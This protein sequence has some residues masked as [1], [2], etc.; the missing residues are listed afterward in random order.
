VRSG[1]RPGTDEARRRAVAGVREALAADP[2]LSLAQ[3]AR[4]LSISPHHLSR[5]FRAQTGE[6]IARHRM[7]L[8]TRTVLERLAAG[9]TDL[10]RLAAESGF[11]DQSHLSRVIRSETGATPRALRAALTA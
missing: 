7:R 2:D 8:R 1:S 3:L 4:E 9:D 6:T 11:A 10:A 5:T